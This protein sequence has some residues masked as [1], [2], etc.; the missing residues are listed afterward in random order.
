MLE[1]N[2]ERDAEEQTPAAREGRWV[3]LMRHQLALFQEL[4]TTTPD[5]PLKFLNDPK[6]LG[7]YQ[8]DYQEEGESATLPRPN[9]GIHV[10]D[11]RDVANCCYLNQENALWEMLRTLQTFQQTPDIFQLR[12]NVL[13][14]LISM[15]REKAL[16]WET[17]RG[18]VMNG[19]YFNTGTFPE[20]LLI[21]LVLL[22]L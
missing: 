18:G 21:F 5:R 9:T 17:C 7:K 20:S 12:L 4:P 19:L 3:E 14:A 6:E 13:E 8:F 16:Q 22:S 11:P 15:E 10:L 1:H 2:T